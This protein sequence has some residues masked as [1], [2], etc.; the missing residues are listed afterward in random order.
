MRTPRISAKIFFIFSLT[1]IAIIT[2][3]SFIF[4]YLSRR[5]ISSQL[6]FRGEALVN[7]LWQKVNFYLKIGGNPK[8]LYGLSTI[9]EQIYENSPDVSE[10]VVMSN[11]GNILAHN[12]TQ[13]IGKIETDLPAVKNQQHIFIET[14]F[15]LDTYLPVIYKNN[16]PLLVRISFTKKPL[17][18][19]MWDEILISVIFSISVVLIFLLLILQ[20]T[21]RLFG[22]RITK[23]LEGFKALADGKL[24]IRLTDQAQ[25]EPKPKRGL[26]ELDFLM[27]SF[28]KMASQLEDIDAKRKQQEKQLSFLATHDQLTALPNRRLL[29]NALKRGVARARRGTK[30]TFMLMDLD[31]FKFVN[32]TLG[33]TTGDKVLV[34]LTSLL[35]KQLRNSDLL[36]RIGGDEFA[37][38]L[39][40]EDTT[41]AKVVAERICQAVEEYRFVFDTHSFHLGLSIGIVPIDGNCDQGTLLSQ[42]DTA[43]YSAKRQGRNRVVL[44]YPEDNT[45]FRL[46]QTN[47][48]VSLVKDALEGE[49]FLLYFQPVVRLEDNRIEHYE[50]LIRLKDNG[51]IISPGAFL[52]AAEQFGLMPLIDRWVVKHVFYTLQEH[53]NIRIFMNLSG[54]S[55][56]DEALLV[57]IEDCM[58]Q[59]GIEPGRIGFEITET[60]VVHDL[61]LAEEWIKRLKLIG[62]RFSLDDFGSGFNSFY[63]LRNLPINQLKLDGTFISSLDSDPTLRC[64]VQAMY[65]LAK[66][67]NIETVAEF[68][69]SAE[70]VRIL[71]EIGVTYGQGYHLGKPSPDFV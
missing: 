38:L 62:C 12:N 22:K 56:A 8:S 4:H 49:G 50:A 40:G 70:V 57:Y 23:F 35:Q 47:E 45:M 3:H 32:D 60:S 68:V 55:L 2:I 6:F 24:D 59:F 9:C 61:D 17:E 44:Y 65:D 58:L 1:I 29:E 7:P 28:D 54:Y 66:A 71:K 43:M 41:E 67:L 26:D 39:E 46:S 30:S 18:K 52:P 36:A 10:V 33:H 37:L 63:Y 64:L 51:K 48:V 27:Q 19:Q 5:T 31:N 13:M 42:A 21:N 69:E 14:P 25:F 15:T 53:P 16:P 20:L 34:T 11:K